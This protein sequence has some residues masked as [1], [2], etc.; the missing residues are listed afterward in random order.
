MS[1]PQDV[2]AII[3]RKKAQYCRFA[4]TNLWERWGEIALPD[5]SYKFVDRDIGGSLVRVQ[6]TEYAWVSSESFVAHFRTAFQQLQTIHVVGPAEMEPLGPDEVR[7][8]WAVVYHAG[9]RGDTGGHHETGGGYY[10]ETWRRRDG[11]WFLAD[12]T[13][14]RTYSNIKVC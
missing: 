2:A 13:M 14:V 11:D 4:D 9:P 10:H 6:G 1:V 8:V 12:L 3:T 5:A 7:A